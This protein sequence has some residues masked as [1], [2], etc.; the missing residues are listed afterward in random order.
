MASMWADPAN[1]RRYLPQDNTV[2]GACSSVHAVRCGCVSHYADD[3]LC[4]LTKHQNGGA[5]LQ[6][7]YNRV[8]KWRH[9]RARI[10]CGTGLQ[11]LSASVDGIS[12]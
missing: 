4:L 5:I 3:K 8:Q 12:D 1:V 2:Y 9:V 7:S 10:I 11:G 6:I